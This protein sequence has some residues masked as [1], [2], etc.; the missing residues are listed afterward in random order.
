TP[1]PPFEPDVSPLLGLSGFGDV[2]PPPFGR[3]GFVGSSVPSFVPELSPSF[4]SDVPS[5]FDSSGSDGVLSSSSFGLSGFDGSPVLS[6]SLESDVSLSL[7]SSVP[8]FVPVLSPSFESD[9]SSS[10]GSSGSDGVL[11]SSFG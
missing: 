8:S 2:P 5:S 1:V 11:S 10:L 6:S 7:G 4:E 9:V 3:P